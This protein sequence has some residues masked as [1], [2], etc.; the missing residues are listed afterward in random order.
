MNNPKSFDRHIKWPQ[1][2][3]HHEDGDHFCHPTVLPWPFITHLPSPLLSPWH[4]FSASCSCCFA[5]SAMSYEWSPTVWSL[6]CLASSPWHGAFEVHQG[7]GKCQDVIP[8][9]RWAAFHW[10]DVPE[11]VSSVHLLRNTWA[12]SIFCLL[13]IKLLWAFFVWTYAFMSLEWI[14]RT[15]VAGSYGRYTFN[16]IGNCRTVV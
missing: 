4:P 14:T 9:Y 5:V 1:W 11:L 7:S 2:S 13:W 15:G 8:S 16:F 6:V 10:K 12:V 3:V